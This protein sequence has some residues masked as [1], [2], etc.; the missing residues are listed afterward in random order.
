MP[1]TYSFH[2]E[3]YKNG[4][5][6]HK[7][8]NIP[9]FS[10]LSL[11]HPQNLCHGS[12]HPGSEWHLRQKPGLPAQRG[13]LNKTRHSLGLIGKPCR[14]AIPL[15]HRTP[16]Q[17]PVPGIVCQSTSMCAHKTPAPYILGERQHLS[18]SPLFP[19]ATTP[20]RLEQEGEQAQHS[21]PPTSFLHPQVREEPS[22]LLSCF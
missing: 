3:F 12:K 7:G 4:F 5:P 20:A 18:G 9:Q 1:I 16:W 2:S 6:R 22:G 8:K 13:T 19:P 15:V 11:P 17:P 10:T 21:A 14:Q